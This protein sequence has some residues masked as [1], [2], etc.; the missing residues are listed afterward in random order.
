MNSHGWA[1]I[2][3]LQHSRV[4]SHITVTW[5]DKC[6]HS[7][8]PLLPFSTPILYT[9]THAIWSGTSP[10]SVWVTCPAVSPPMYPRSLL[11]CGSKKS[12]QGLGSVQ[13]LLTNRKNCITSPEFSTGQNHSPITAPGNKMNSTPAKTSRQV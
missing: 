8:C 2:Q 12:R 9:E 7:L 5:E 11:Q 6:H 3:H 1:G 13:A 4:P 10:G